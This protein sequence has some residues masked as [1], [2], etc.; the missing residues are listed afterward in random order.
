MGASSRGHGI[1]NAAAGWTGLYGLLKLYWACGGTGLRDLVEVP[2]GSWTDP[3]MVIFGLW[4]TVMLAVIGCG[5]A[6]SAVRGWGGRLARPWVVAGCWFAAGI[7]SLR[8]FPSLVADGLA[9]AGLIGDQPLP[10]HQ[11][12]M[13]RIDLVLWAPFFT[14][15]AVLWTALAWHV[16]RA[17]DDRS[18]VTDPPTASRPGPTR[19]S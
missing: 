6:L 8:A 12:R 4:G 3:R 14:V 5:V 19:R 18:P 16:T 17:R 1:A 13:V 9:L 10:G 2:G 7:L 15:W 11:A